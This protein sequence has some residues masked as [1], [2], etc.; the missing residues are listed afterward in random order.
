MCK[1]CKE[2]MFNAEF[3]M[4]G[5]KYMCHECKRV[6]TMEKWREWQKKQSKKD[7]VHA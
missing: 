3:L 7:K 4:I 6:M 1:Y 5:V 2:K